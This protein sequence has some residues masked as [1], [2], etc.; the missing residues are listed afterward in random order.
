MAL[1][2]GP[3]PDSIAIGTAQRFTWSQ[4]SDIYDSVEILSLRELPV[5]Y[6]RLPTLCLRKPGSATALRQ[7]MLLTPE[8]V[9]GQEGQ[10]LSSLRIILSVGCWAAEELF[11]EVNA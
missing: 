9:E 5:E 1:A 8:C 10:E 11:S 2:F 7:R 6:G 3:M 4:Q